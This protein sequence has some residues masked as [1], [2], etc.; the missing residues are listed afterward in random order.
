MMPSANSLLCGA[1]ALHRP[2]ESPRLESPPRA[3]QFSGLKGVA[4]ELKLRDEIQKKLTVAAAKMKTQTQ[5]Q[6]FNT[7]SK[8]MKTNPQ[9]APGN[10]K[11]VEDIVFLK[12]FM[13]KNNSPEKVKL[14][15]LTKNRGQFTNY[16]EFYKTMVASA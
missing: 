3:K 11:S 1:C 6:M 15:G 12:I 14:R 10:L 5:S 7:A 16:E 2:V 8:R 13:G 9:Q 4:K